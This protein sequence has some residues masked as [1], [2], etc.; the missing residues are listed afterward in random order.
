MDLPIKNVAVIGAGTLG[1]QIALVAA[2]A[3]YSV[4]VFDSDPKALDKSADRLGRE[5]RDKQADSIVPVENWEQLL[6]G[7]TR[8]DDLERAVAGA[9]LVIESVPEQLELKRE[10]FE[11]LGRVAPAGALLATNSSSLPV[12]RWAEDSGRPESC[13]NIHFYAPLRGPHMADVMGCPQTRPEVL[14]MG[15]DWVRS[16][17]FTPLT[18]K[19]EQMGF[20]FNRLWWAIKHQVLLMWAGGYVD[21]RDV[22][23]AWMIFSRMPMGPFGLMDS[24][25][26]DVVYD[27]GRQ[28]YLDSGEERDAPPRALLEMVESGR[29]G[30]KAG[31]GFYTYPDPEF[32]RPDFL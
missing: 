31:Q 28:Y 3:G 14:V 25:G 21:F 18:V 30:V 17:G 1:F 2:Q 15:A 7:M 8:A 13:L 12:S 27:I 4:T 29:L 19:K 22:D 10:V 20:C 11:Q 16:L 6:A 24:I 5:L 9:D 23:R 32:A 26:L